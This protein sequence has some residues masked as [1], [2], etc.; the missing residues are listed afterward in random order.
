M[1]FHDGR[2][3]EWLAA[4]CWAGPC[5]PSLLGIDAERILRPSEGD[6]CTVVCFDRAKPV[7]WR[8]V[9]RAESGAYVLESPTGNYV[10]PKG[11]GAAFLYFK[12]ETQASAVLQVT[13]SGIRTTGWLDGEALAFAGT[14]VT[15]ADAGEPPAAG[16]QAVGRTDQG[17]SFSVAVTGRE[18]PV[19]AHLKL[20]PGWHRVLLK[21]VMQHK[22]G[23]TFQFSARFVDQAGNPLPAIGTVVDPGTELS[24]HAVAR[25][26]VP[27]LYVNDPVSLPRPG[28]PLKLHIEFKHVPAITAG[29]Q[30]IPVL[31]LGAKLVLV[32]TDYDGTEVARREVNA[33]LP[34]TLDVDFG[35]APEAGYYSLRPTLLSPDGNTVIA[36]Y[37]PDGFSVIGGATAQKERKNSKKMATAYYFLASSPDRHHRD[38]V[39]VKS[40]FHWM[41]RM[42]IYRNVGSSPGFSKELWD[43]ADETGIA[44]SADFWDIHNSDSP[45]RKQALA[46]QTAGYGRWYKSF[47]EVD[48]VPKTRGTAE[49]WV[50][51]T[52]REHEAVKAARADGFYV[53]GSL[54]RVGAPDQDGWFEECLKL[55]LD[56]YQDAWDVHAYPQHP[57][58]L[59]GSISN[60][61]SETDLG[62]LNA[63]RKIGRVNTLPFWLGETG[64]RSCHGPDA[65]RWQ[66]EMVAKMTAWANSRSDFQVIAFL[67]PFYYSRNAP[68]V[69]G[70]AGDAEGDIQAGH[71]PAEAAYYTASALVD[72]LPYRR[73]ESV[74]ATLQAG[75]FGETLMLWTT[76]APVEYT[77]PLGDG[78][79]LTVDVVGRVGRL[80]VNPLG[81]AALRLTTSPV[82][83]LRRT[84]YERLTARGSN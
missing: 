37:P 70:K 10:W 79:W 22:E 64:A 40:T 77:L 45:D 27:Y 67:I 63:Y 80:A 8:A 32:M 15:P 1:P 73:I 25:R 41:D 78:D 51:R 56:K 24:R 82:Y 55:G 62:V 49:H 83:I 54:V 59:G 28:D 26:L 11:S 14:A 66:A 17:N 81:V 42:G 58:L 31:P 5:G 75:Y 68:A 29:G 74:D 36:V 47:N 3:A 69:A 72:G 61:P 21:F 30:A 4:G 16:E 33:E 48:I 60:S 84:H 6:P 20:V 52:R 18:G 43:M 2:P 39:S 65:R 76:G 35:T 53:G 13:Q 57:P 44:L 12:V 9:T 38:G 7:S 46:G 71:Q 34:G 50:N 19:A 23:E